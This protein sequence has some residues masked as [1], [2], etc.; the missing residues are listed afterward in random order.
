MSHKTLV[1]STRCSFCC[2]LFSTSVKQRTNEFKMFL[3]PKK[4]RNASFPFVYFLPLIKKQN[5]RVQ[6][7]P[8]LKKT[9]EGLRGVR[10]NNG[11]RLNQWLKQNVNVNPL[12][13]REKQLLQNQ[14]CLSLFGALLLARKFTYTAHGILLNSWTGWQS[15]PR[16]PQIGWCRCPMKVGFPWTNFQQC[17][18]I[19]SSWSELAHVS[20][21]NSRS[22][23]LLSELSWQPYLTEKQATTALPETDKPRWVSSGELQSSREC[24]VPCC[25]CAVLYPHPLLHSTLTRNGIKRLPCGIKWDPILTTRIFLLH[26]HSA[27]SKAATVVT[28]AIKFLISA[29]KATCAASHGF[30]CTTG[31]AAVVELSGP[32]CTWGPCLDNLSN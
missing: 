24:I 13:F 25:V 11:S 16:H 6:K 10:T 17:H 30:P 14:R 28:V 22:A 19:S 12:S 20:V 26:L 27:W 21:L 15:K 7:V 32:L 31:T 18:F 5:V 8:T 1:N 9:M 4:T 3:V 29:R 23:D 2:L